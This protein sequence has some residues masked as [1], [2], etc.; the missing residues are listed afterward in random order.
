MNQWALKDSLFMEENLLMV[1]I[2]SV[3]IVTNQYM[4]QLKPMFL[5]QVLA[6]CRN[7]KGLSDFNQH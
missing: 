1:T 7:A 2:Q 5:L 6:I 4:N 3:T